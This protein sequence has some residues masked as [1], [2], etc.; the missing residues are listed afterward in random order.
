MAN[1]FKVVTAS[2][3]EVEGVTKVDGHEARYRMPALTVELIP[4]DGHSG[5]IKLVFRGKDVEEAQK[6]YT[7]DKVVDVP[8]HLPDADDEDVKASRFAPPK[9]GA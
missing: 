7:I 5:T 2:I 4:E 6:H 9:E 1:L 3:G 8:V